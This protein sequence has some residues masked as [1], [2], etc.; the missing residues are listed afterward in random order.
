[1]NR[2]AKAGAVSELCEYLWPEIRCGMRSRRVRNTYRL[3][4]GLIL[5]AL[6]SAAQMQVGDNLQMN[7]NGNIGFT[8]AGGINQGQSD[9]SMGF[10]GNGNLTGNYYSPNFLN[11]N[12][13][14][15]YNRADSSSVFG[16]L[17]NTT[18]VTANANLFSGSHFP[19][20]VSYNRLFNS[21]S[22]FGVPGSDIGL[23]QHTNTQGYGIGWSA[24]IPDWPTL[25]ANYSVNQNSN[26]IL[27]LQGN[28]D[29]TDHTLNLLSAYKWDG[30]R[31]TGQFIH[32]NVDANFSE[33]LDAAAPVRTNSS[34]DSV[35][36]TVQ[37][38]LPM[39]GNFSVS[40]NHLGYDYAYK[41]AYSA[42]NSG[43]STTVNGN[44]SFH[45]TNKLGVAFNANYSDSLLGNVP[46]PILNNGTVVNMTSLGSF[47]SE[48][49]GTDVY[50]QVFRNLGV[51]GDV[52]HVNQSFLG[53][54]YSATQFFGS[55]NFNF[56]RT[57]LK[58]LSFSLGVVDT[59]QQ[60]SNTGL[61]FVGTV[62]Y[63]RKFSGWEVSANF[64][65]AQNVQ[66]VMLVYT[67]SSYSYLG[68][69]R[70]RIGD[71]TYFM[72]GYSGAH[73]GITANSGST[74]GAERVWTTFMH[75]GYTLNAY[76]NKS[77]GE[78][79]LTANGLVPV[80]GNLPPPVLGPNEFTSYD[81]KGWGFNAGATPIRRLTISAGFSKSNGHTIDPLL[82]TA[83]NNEL[84][85]AVMQ[86]RLR[87]IFLNAGYTRL[88]QTVGVP[89]A[90][91]IMVTS[92]FVG[93]SRW[94]NFF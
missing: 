6:P 67:T 38:S 54:S 59:A 62:N 4:A 10:S 76:Y 84:I 52:T 39:A 21:T 80:P 49:V 48:Q 69:V 27:G 1:M 35:G 13:D 93:I 47:R 73:S 94:F 16:S 37:H 34:S 36:A 30:F 18:G 20:T 51:H 45:P 44:A 82:T 85:N 46:E 9:H 58:G 81:S 91:P 75:R 88:S 25:T 66:T 2:P 90:Q 68:S 11:F 60:T 87:K 63:T 28:N 70:R 29:E 22:Q 57:L 14:P 23:A 78:A 12:V 31:M 71:R 89:G 64:S 86:Y 42:K 41:D 83:T 50:Y 77:N 40:W 3:L 61:G 32:R 43:D 55:A 53:K 72:A 65:Y 15:F 7:L 26:S 24:L 17:T 79:I 19:G 56:E 5:L 33:F 8:Y 74:S 92:Y